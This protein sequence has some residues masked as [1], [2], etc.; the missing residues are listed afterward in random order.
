[1]ATPRVEKAVRRCPAV[2]NVANL[3]SSIAALSGSESR[4]AGTAVLADPKLNVL[5][6]FNRLE[7]LFVIDL[8]AR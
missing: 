4:A 3:K 5:E 1:M 8:N 2:S 7:E 6:R